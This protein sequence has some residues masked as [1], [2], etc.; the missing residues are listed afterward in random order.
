MEILFFAEDVEM[1][2]IE[3]SI[4]KT[5][6]SNIIKEHKKQLGAINYIF[7][8]DDYLLDI[9]KQHLN[10]DYYT[11]IISFNY[12][13]DDIIS[14]D[15]FISICRVNDNAQEYNTSDTELLRVIV[16]GLLHFLGYDDK[17]EEEQNLMRQKENEYIDKYLTIKTKIKC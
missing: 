4:I 2:Q 16:H 7:C 9:N 6:I 3:T 14:G 12:C 11:D 5:W 10:H 13:E 1:P 17:I 15:I 8:S